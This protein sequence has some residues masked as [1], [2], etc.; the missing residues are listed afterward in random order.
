[1]KREEDGTVTMS[2]ESKMPQGDVDTLVAALSDQCGK[3][4]YNHFE[5]VTANEDRTVFTIVINDIHI[6]EK[7]KQAVT[8]L[9]L[10]AG[11]QVV[12]SGQDVENIRVETVNKLGKLISARNSNP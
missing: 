1:M 2:A 5:S 4:G 9:F 7:E 12:Q 10:M 8:D 11:L 6:N 3:S